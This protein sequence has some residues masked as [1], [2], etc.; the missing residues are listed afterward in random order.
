[1]SHEICD[2][3]STKWV[4]E[5]RDEGGVKKKKKKKKKRKNGQLHR[6]SYSFGENK[7]YMSHEGC[8]FV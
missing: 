4:V 8:D 1:M 7:S 3:V 2:F 6:C 5:I